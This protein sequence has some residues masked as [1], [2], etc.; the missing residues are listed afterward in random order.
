MPG[1]KKFRKY[2]KKNNNE[3]KRKLRIRVHDTT[4]K[5]KDSK[6]ET[7][8]SDEKYGLITEL[9]GSTMFIVLDE[10]K[11]MR[12][13][14]LR[15]KIRGN[16]HAMIGSFVI[17]N[18]D[19]ARESKK[20]EML[21]GSIDHKYNSNELNALEQN[22]SKFKRSN[23]GNN[24]GEENDLPDCFTFDYSEEEKKPIRIKDKTSYNDIYNDINYKSDEEIEVD[25]I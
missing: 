12:K 25:D 8:Y 18:F 3:S 2:K 19:I 7:R 20:G 6:T 17:F 23:Y 4:Y 5:T 15:G 10:D 13:C 16:K 14:S 1:G 21:S 22:D 11:N 24:K 9:K